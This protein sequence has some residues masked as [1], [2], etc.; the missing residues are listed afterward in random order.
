MGLE[1]GTKL[2]DL[3]ASW[4]LG[5]DPRSEGD[6][7]LRLVKSVLQT[8]AAS[9][10]DGGEF[11]TAPTVPDG[12]TGKQVPNAD[13]I[14]ALAGLEN[15]FHDATGGWRII[16]TTL[17]CWGSVT[18]DA[19][20]HAFVTF[21]KVF[22]AA[23]NIQAAPSATAVPTTITRSVTWQSLSTAGVSLNVREVQNGGA[24]LP[25][26]PTIMWHAIGE[27]DGVS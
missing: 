6:D 1:T 21:P 24:V 4:P 8:D 14:P 11:A 5:S 26:A 2:A 10:A 20:G 12:A 17:E 25:V 19:N 16:G 3:N 27:W 9:L 22:S 7:H 13:E 23:P 18:P 15:V